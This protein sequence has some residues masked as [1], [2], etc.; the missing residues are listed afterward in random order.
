MGSA[1]TQAVARQNA[2]IDAS[3]ARAVA[4]REANENRPRSALEAM[5]M[6]LQVTPQVLQ[7]TLRS[8]V[9]S[10]CRNNEEFVALVVVANEYG[11]NPLL[12]EIYAFP[13][14]GG[15]I[16]PMVSIDGW[17]R[18]MNEHPQFDGIEFAHIVDGKGALEAIEAI[19]YRKDRG[20]SI[21]VIEYLDEN[22][23]GT[24]PWK[25]MPSRMLRHRA[26]I[27]GARIAFGFSGV[28][29]EG[30]EIELVGQSATATALPAQKS[31]AEELD[32]EIPSFDGETGEVIEG[33]ARDAAGMSEV[34]EQTARELDAGTVQSDP[35]SGVPGTTEQ[36]PDDTD[37][38]E[39]G[40]A[41]SPAEQFLMTL[42]ESIEAAED[43]TALKAVDER[44]TKNRAAYDDATA[45][46][47]DKL[48]TAKRK[49]LAAEAG[50]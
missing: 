4:A 40:D 8:T 29:S 50:K 26:L 44:W 41:I 47:I 48:I 20:H 34:D 28:A 39:P 45:E 32:D 21:K 16:V 2:E 49:A 27:Q 36:R 24:E 42:R 9:F 14:K 11:L 38:G 43:K 23:R 35:A 12:K 15:G 25:Q 22:K 6:R 19:I 31:L 1:R 13:A 3:T 30:D 5:A 37:P 10:A 46:G 33:P 7:S 18:I 17:I